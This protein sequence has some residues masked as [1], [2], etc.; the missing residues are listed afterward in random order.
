MWCKRYNEECEEALKF[1]CDIPSNNVNTSNEYVECI[2]CCFV[3]E[4]K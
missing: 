3:S 1:H 2:E 4:T